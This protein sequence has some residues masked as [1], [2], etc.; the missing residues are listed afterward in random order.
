MENRAHALL[1]GS[2]LVFFISATLLALWW[3]GAPKE[4]MRDILLLSRHSVSGLN[5]QAAVRYRGVRVGKVRAIRFDTEQNDLILVELK[6]AANAPIPEKAIAR[7]AYQ[8]VTGQAYVLLEDAPN[9]VPLPQ[10]GDAL[11]LSLQPS[12]VSEGIDTGMELLRQVKE[13]SVRINTLLDNSHRQK[14]VNTLDNVE[15]ISAQLALSS[16]ALPDILQRLQKILNEDNVGRI[17]KTLKNT[18]DASGQVGGVLQDT[19]QLVQSLRQVSERMDQAVS[20]ANSLDKE[21]I[22][23]LPIRINGLTNKLNDSLE[24]LDRLVKKLEDRPESLL[25]GRASGEPGPGEHK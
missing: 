5:A 23:S 7:L 17:E 24:G 1:A 12:L 16:R 10:D 9:L 25:F 14:I 8:G 19:R 2:F 6:V 18:A 4:S 21:A 15:Q 22:A 3:F 13:V 20:V 11:R